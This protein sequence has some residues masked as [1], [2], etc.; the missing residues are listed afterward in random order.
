MED[1]NNLKNLIAFIQRKAFIWGPEPEIYN[2]IAGFYTYGPLGKELKNNVENTIRKTFK[3]NELWEVECPTVSPAPVWK[4]SGH[5]DGFTDPVITCSKCN[6]NFRADNLISEFFRN[7]EI[8]KSTDGLSKEDLLKLIETENITCPSCKGSFQKEIKEHNLMMKTTLGL[9]IEAYNRPET[10]TTTYLPFPRYLDFFRDKLPFGVF[11]IGK[12]YRNEISPRQFVL[13][14]RE[15]TQAE[16]QIFIFEEQKQDYEKF[17]NIKNDIMPIW[18]EE[19]QEKKLEPSLISLDE[20]L[21]RGYL[22]NKAYAWTLNLA[23]K[24]FKNLGISDEYIRLRQHC[25]D[26]KAFY[27][28]DA[29]DIELKLNSFGWTEVCGVHDRTDYD[30][31]KHEQHSKTSLQARNENNE[32]KTPHVLEIAFGTD[33]PTFALLDIFYSFDKEKNQDI[34]KIPEHI[35]PVKVSILPLV[36][37]D[38]LKEI[39]QELYLE[40][41]PQLETTIDFSGSIGRRYARN[42][43]IGTPYCITIDYETKEKNTVTIRNRDTCEQK[44]IKIDECLKII[45]NLIQKKINFADI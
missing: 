23:Y 3:E 31:T 9:D 45:K 1:K 8:E 16:G 10:A 18:S 4:A 28:D 22:K 33:R 17:E 5:L 6:S 44:R 43:E 40:L 19:L 42:D 24:L 15:F 26:E 7:K 36:K 35:A 27:A 37:K 21:K 25:S 41:K 34:L 38:G 20:A 13:R 29:W 14:S 32:K 30:L 39:A 2:G 12:A 11:Q